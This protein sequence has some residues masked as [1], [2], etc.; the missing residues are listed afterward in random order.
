MA[1]GRAR[2]HRWHSRLGSALGHFVVCGDKDTYV[3]NENGVL[4][5]NIGAN[6]RVNRQI[7]SP[8][9]WLEVVETTDGTEVHATRM[10]IGHKPS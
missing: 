5:V 4:T 3:V 1:A 10:V 2:P 7:Y 6:N 8:N 9:G